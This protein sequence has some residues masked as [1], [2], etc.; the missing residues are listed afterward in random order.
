MGVLSNLSVQHGASDLIDEQPCVIAIRKSRINPII[1]KESER[2][3]KRNILP[4]CGRVSPFCLKAHILK[5][6][7]K[8]KLK[9][10]QLKKLKNL[11]RS[12]IGWKGYYIDAGKLKRVELS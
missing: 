3:I 5:T 10:P 2:F 6:A 11:F 12:R 9:S 4:D 8:L 7:K 1:K